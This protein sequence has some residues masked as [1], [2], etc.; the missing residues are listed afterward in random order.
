MLYTFYVRY[1]FIEILPCVRFNDDDDDDI[2]RFAYSITLY[3][4]AIYI[5]LR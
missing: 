4:I 5:Y 1:S 3:K 2:P